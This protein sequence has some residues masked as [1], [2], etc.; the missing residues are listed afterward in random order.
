M[1]RRLG[2]DTKTLSKF[3]RDKHL[4]SLATLE[5]LASILMTIIAELLDK[6]PQP[7]DDNHYILIT[8]P[9]SR[10]PCIHQTLG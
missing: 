6:T 5:R 1:R 2:I 9:K 3:E 8:S 4:P 10:G 7:P